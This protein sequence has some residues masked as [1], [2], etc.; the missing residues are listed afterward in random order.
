[1]RGLAGTGIGFLVIDHDMGFLMPLA[2]RLACLHEGRLIASGPAE[3][4]RADPA[5][6]EA[7]LGPDFQVAGGGRP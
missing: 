7:Y 1:L 6:I 4:V 2:G 5:V 3:A